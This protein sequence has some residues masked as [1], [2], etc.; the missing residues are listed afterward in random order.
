MVSLNERLGARVFP[1]PDD[2]HNNY[3]ACIIVLG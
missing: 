1:D 2:P 3:F